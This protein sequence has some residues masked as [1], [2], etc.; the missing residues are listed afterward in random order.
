MRTKTIL[1]HLYFFNY[2]FFIGISIYHFLFQKYIL[3]KI[4]G[5]LKYFNKQNK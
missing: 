5:V 2:I 3:Y 4:F 1:C